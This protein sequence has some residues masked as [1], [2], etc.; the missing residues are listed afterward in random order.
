MF[1]LFRKKERTKEKSIL[2]FSRMVTDYSIL[3]LR[4]SSY[5]RRRA[6]AA[7]RCLLAMSQRLLLNSI[8]RG[9]LDSL[10]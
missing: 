8:I 5:E 6:Y 9:S 7:L 2:S 4:L 3:G 10:F 1:F